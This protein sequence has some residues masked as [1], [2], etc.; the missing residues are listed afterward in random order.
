MRRVQLVI[1]EM[2]VNGF[3]LFGKGVH[4]QVRHF[5]AHMPTVGFELQ[6]CTMAAREIEAVVTLAGPTR[7][8]QEAAALQALCK[9]KRVVYP[10]GAP[11]YYPPAVRGGRVRLHAAKPLSTGP[12]L[13]GTFTASKWVHCAYVPTQGRGSRHRSV[14]PGGVPIA[15]R[16]AGSRAAPTTLAKPS[17]T[18]RVRGEGSQLSPRDRACLAKYADEI[19]KAAVMT[20]HDASSTHSEGSSEVLHSIAAS[21]RRRHKTVRAAAKS[22][23]VVVLGAGF[24]STGT[25]VVAS[26]LAQVGLTSWRAPEL[27]LGLKDG[28]ARSA[29]NMTANQ[30]RQKIVQP[31]VLASDSCNKQLDKVSYKVPDEVDAYLDRPSAE[32]FLDMWWTYPNAKVILSSR[33]TPLE[34]ARHRT[35]HYASNG[36]LNAPVARP[37]GSARVHKLS[38]AANAH[39]VSA[40]AELVRCVVPKEQLLE[41]PSCEKKAEPVPLGCVEPQNSYA[42]PL[43]V[44][45]N[46]AGLSYSPASKCTLSLS[47]IDLIQRLKKFVTAPP[48]KPRGWF[49]L[50]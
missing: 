16:T 45:R 18:H 33:S 2:D 6:A 1:S 34:W 17:S 46:A 14:S 47:A 21:L 23:R 25:D 29:P 41:L 19:D 13:D 32:A 27:Y 9:Q 49:G 22:Q 15:D 7:L 36:G 20:A 40:H 26:A 5:E 12:L 43:Q 30:W 39:L 48:R 44:C 8:K 38:L 31:W 42:D 3:E 50:W 37:C 4:N 24:G 35:E 10:C 28:V 11:T